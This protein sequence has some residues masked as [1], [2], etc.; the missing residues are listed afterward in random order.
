MKPKIIDYSQD[1]NTQTVQ[2]ITTV[3]PRDCVVSE[4]EYSYVEHGTNEAKIGVEI[5]LSTLSEDEEDRVTC[6]LEDLQKEEGSVPL[7]TLADD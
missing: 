7:L 3:T 5:T 1:E 2:V 4:R 6:S